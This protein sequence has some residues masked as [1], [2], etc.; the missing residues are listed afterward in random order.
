MTQFVALLRAVNV[1]GTG[2]LPMKDLMALCSNLGFKKVRTYIQSGNVVFES[3]LSEK[4]IRTRLEKVLTEKL[5]RQANVVVR[6]AAELRAVLQGNPFTHAQPSKVGVYF[7]S[8][9][10]D[11][12]LL[13]EAGGPGGEEIRLGKRE[14]YIHF[15]H[16]MGRSK[17]RL[18]AG[19]GTVRNMNTVTKLV[20]MTTAHCD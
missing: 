1:G 10:V 3:G 16:G 2:K 15:P 8:D 7:Q 4:T 18:P 14:V 17:L 5:G 9:R 12:R 19:I 11:E 20:A 6:T 13:N